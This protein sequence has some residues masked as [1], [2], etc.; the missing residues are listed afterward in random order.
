M[1]LAFES[2]STPMEFKM[3]S[4]EG[5]DVS[6]STISPSTNDCNNEIYKFVD[7]FFYYN[8]FNFIFIYLEQLYV[9]CAVPEKNPYSPQGRS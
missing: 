7:S 4:H 2:L 6:V 1:S 8:I 9:K 3:T 5:M